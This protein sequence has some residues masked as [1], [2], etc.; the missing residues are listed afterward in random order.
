[1]TWRAAL[2]RSPV[3]ITPDRGTSVRREGPCN[4]RVQFTARLTRRRRSMLGS[5]DLIAFV[6][7]KNP[8]RAKVF[9]SDVLGLRLVEDNPFALVFDAAGIM[10]RVS[11]VHELTPA[12]YTVLGWE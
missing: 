1:M 11:K 10:L 4:E 12:P 8:D 9:Y 7:T 6:S 2:L 5:C 3:E